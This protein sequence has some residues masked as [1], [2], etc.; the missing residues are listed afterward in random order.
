VYGFKAQP[1]AG[2]AVHCAVAFTM[3]FGQNCEQVQPTASSKL[4][5]LVLF[6]VHGIASPQVVAT[7]WSLVAVQLQGVCGKTRSFAGRIHSYSSWYEE[8]TFATCDV[9][10]GGRGTPVSDGGRMETG[11]CLLGYERAVLAPFI[12]KPG[13]RQSKNKRLLKILAICAMM[14]PEHNQ[15]AIIGTLVGEHLG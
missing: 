10:G 2:V 15:R 13:T 7:N 9:G 8:P 14:A 12:A 5:H 1:F 4:A 11:E 6:K 3:L